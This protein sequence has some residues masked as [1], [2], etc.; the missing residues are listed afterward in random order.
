MKG[1][2]ANVTKKTATICDIDFGVV[3][4]MVREVY[5]RLEGCWPACGSGHPRCNIWK[6][7]V[8]G[9]SEAGGPSELADFR[10]GVVKHRGPLGVYKRS[11]AN[12]S[13]LEVCFWE[14][15]ADLLWVAESTQDGGR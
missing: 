5:W 15:Q 1:L 10:K 7:V 13:F 3:Q 4:E 2:H 9:R 11:S 8:G 14:C 6:A 12:G